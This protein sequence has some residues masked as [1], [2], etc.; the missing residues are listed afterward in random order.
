VLPEVREVWQH[1]V[2]AGHLFVREG[3][4]GIHGQDATPAPDGGHVLAD[5]PQP[6]Q[7]DDLQSLVV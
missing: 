5:L 7:G 3:K 1:Q 6:S 2:Y 4:A